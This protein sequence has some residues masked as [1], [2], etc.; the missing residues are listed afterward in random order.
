MSARDFIEDTMLPWLEAELAEQVPGNKRYVAGFEDAIRAFQQ[1]I[2]H[3]RLEWDQPST[4]EPRV[5]L[6]HRNV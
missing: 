2:E 5:D 4:E 6:I 1:F 3:G